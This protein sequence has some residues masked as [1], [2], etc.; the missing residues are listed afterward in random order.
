MAGSQSTNPVSFMSRKFI[1]RAKAEKDMQKAFK[2]YEDCHAGLGKK[3]LEEAD[4]VFQRIQERPFE[5]AVVHRNLRRALMQGF[6]YGIFFLLADDSI[7]VVAVTHH[8][9]NPSEWQERI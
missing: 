7:K 9:Q 3:F 4:R 8:A 2:W 5:C 6:P 1:V